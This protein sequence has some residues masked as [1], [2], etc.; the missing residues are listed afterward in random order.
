MALDGSVGS[1]RKVVLDEI[2][3]DICLR[4]AYL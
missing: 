3:V 1:K 4:V 2:L